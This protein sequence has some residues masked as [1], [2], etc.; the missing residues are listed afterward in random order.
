MKTKIFYMLLGITLITHELS[1]AT[2]LQT[3]LPEYLFDWI[4]PNIYIDDSNTV[5]LSHNFDISRYDITSF[6]RD[7]YHCALRYIQNNVLSR[8]L[9]EL[10][11]QQILKEITTIHYLLSKRILRNPGRF[12]Q[13]HLYST[14]SS[15][16]LPA[17]RRNFLYK[18]LLTYLGTDHQRLQ[19]YLHLLERL[20]EEQ[21]TNMLKKGLTTQ[22]EQELST[23]VFVRIYANYRDIPHLMEA[24]IDRVKIML[25]EQEDPFKVAAYALLT[26]LYIHPFSNGNGRTS[27]L[28]MNILLAQSGFPPIIFFDRTQYISTLQQCMYIYDEGKHYAEEQENVIR[29]ANY[30]R[31]KFKGMKHELA[32]KKKKKMTPY[33]CLIPKKSF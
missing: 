4:R 29:F 19:A 10:S 27:R 25:K 3:K 16:D 20:K 9:V 30:L 23:K 22:I 18:E 5:F 13:Y 32:K 6:D 12:R 21:P 24:F 28:F 2:R 7:D 26:F 17:Q 8:N 15:Q 33:C 1:G 11:T 31:K 14:I